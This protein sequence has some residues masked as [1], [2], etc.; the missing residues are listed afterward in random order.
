VAAVVAAQVQ[1]ARISDDALAFAA[2][3]DRAHAVVDTVPAHAPDPSASC[4]WR[5]STG[6]RDRELETHGLA[7]RN[8]EGDAA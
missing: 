1:E 7:L 8:D 4:R 2:S 6:G 5:L 3:D